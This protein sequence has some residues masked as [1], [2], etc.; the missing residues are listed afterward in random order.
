MIYPYEIIAIDTSQNKSNAVTKVIETRDVTSPENV[1]DFDIKEEEKK[2]ILTWKNPLD[3]D[4]KMI[5]LYRNDLF[6][7]EGLNQKYVDINVNEGENYTYTII[8]IDENENQSNGVKLTV[9][10]KLRPPMLPIQQFQVEP[11]EEGLKLTWKNPIDDRFLKTEIYRDGKLIH[12]TNQEHYL[13]TE[14]GVYKR[15]YYQIITKDKNGSS[16]SPINTYVLTKDET[17]PPIEHLNAVYHDNEILLTWKINGKNNIKEYHIYRDN[18]YIGKTL[19]LQYRDQTVENGKRYEYKVY[20]VSQ[21]GLLSPIA[22]YTINLPG[23]STEEFFR[24]DSILR[25]KVSFT[26]DK[27]FPFFEKTL[28]Q[29]ENKQEVKGVKKETT[30]ITPQKTKKEKNQKNNQRILI[31]KDIEHRE[32][33]SK[34]LW[35]YVGIAIGCLGIV[36]TVLSSL[37]K[38][39]K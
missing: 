21:T 15:Y 7:Y 8:S 16:Y 6:I 24:S 35:I 19:S 3:S 20:A 12:Q 13:D 25:N 10:K 17:P 36:G 39:K 32:K 14:V 30:V 28:I 26:I 31:K 11:T 5:R 27:K 22:N 18:I 29:V 4:L 9:Q 23:F 34:H 37:I 2:F 38:L 33:Q 1:I